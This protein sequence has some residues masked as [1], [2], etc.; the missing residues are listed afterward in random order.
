LSKALRRVRRYQP[1]AEAHN[2]AL[3][4]LAIHEAGLYVYG[5]SERAPLENCSFLID[6]LD[7]GLSIDSKYDSIQI[8]AIE[9]E[10]AG[11]ATKYLAAIDQHVYI[12]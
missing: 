8:D 1:C 10:Q 2:E 7:F 11:K 9:D 6:S 3:G 12:S 4:E 5:E